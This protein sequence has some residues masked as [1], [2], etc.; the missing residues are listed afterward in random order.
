MT[1]DLSIWT[2]EVLGLFNDR[3][4]D[5]DIA[6][7][8][9]RSLLKELSQDDAKRWKYNP[10]KLIKNI[11]LATTA[12]EMLS[13]KNSKTIETHA[14]KTA[15][16]KLART[17]ESLAKLEERTDMLTATI[18]AAVLYEIAGYQANAAC[19]GKQI[20]REIIDRN[21]G[22]SDLASH[23]LR[24][25]FLQTGIIA[26]P[27]LREPSIDKE[28]DLLIED[29]A[30]ALAAKGFM[31]AGHYFLTGYK[32][33]MDKSMNSFQTSESVYSSLPKYY[34][35][36]LVNSI[37]CLLP[38]MQM[39]ST[40]SYFEREV[41]M[42]PKWERYL[43]LLARGP[44]SDI[45]R[46]PSVSELWPSQLYALNNGLFHESSKIIRMQT[47]AGK[48]RIA[49]LAMANTLITIPESKCVY[50]APYRALVGEL[51]ETFINVFGDLGYKV[52][53]IVDNAYALDDLEKELIN[54]ADI[55]VLTPEKL[56]LL[57][58]A[59]P[60]LLESVALFILDE[61]HIVDERARGIKFELL[62]SRLKRRLPNARFIFL[63][64]VVPQQTLDDFAE[65]FNAE[66]SDII[67]TDWRPSILRVASFEWKG[68]T[69]QIDYSPDEDMPIRE[70][71]PGVIKQNQYEMV[72]NK[73]KRTRVVFPDPTN[74]SETAAELAWKFAELGSVLVFCSQT[75]FV[76][77]VGKAL[78]T[79]LEYSMKQAESIPLRFDPKTSLSVSAAR[80][81]L[82]DNHPVTQL[83][84]RGIGI[85][86][87]TLPEV[88]RKSV[89]TD[90]RNRR[91]R[92]LV[93]TNTLAQGVNLP[94]RTVIVH[95][96]WRHV[97][98]QQKLIPAR[99]YWNIV[100]RAGR[101]GEETQG[102]AIHIIKSERDKSDFNFFLERRNDVEAVWSA[103]LKVLLEWLEKRIDQRELYRLI[104][105]EILA[106]L[107][108]EGEKF[109]SEE[110]IDNILN[111]TLVNVQAK[112]IPDLDMKPLRK[113]FQFAA[114][115]IAATVDTT[116]RPVYSS[117]GL[118]TTSCEKI[119][120]FVVDNDSMLRE[121]LTTAISYQ[122]HVPKLV[123]F[124]LTLEEME[125]DK[126]VNI[127]PS[128]MLLQWLQGR[129]IKD[130]IGYY[131]NDLEPSEITEFIENFFVYR[132]PWGI[133]GIIQIATKV[134]SL[135]KNNLSDLAKFFPSMIKYGV[136]SPSASWAVSAGI[137]FRDV[138][139]RMG[140]AYASK[141]SKHSYDDF[142]QYIGNLHSE[143]LHYEYNITS[144]FLEEVT[145]ALSK[146]STNPYL[147]NYKKDLLTIET[148]VAGI[149]FGRVPIATIAK[150][151]NQVEL[152]RE[153]DNEVDRNAI[154]VLLNGQQLGYLER[155]LAQRLA[156]DMD[157]G[158]QISGKIKEIEKGNIPQIRL[159]INA[160]ATS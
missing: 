21:P 112:R 31:D 86:Y 48:T 130:I 14:I 137:P 120:K 17:W 148:W 153:Y 98:D 150:V 136:P 117:T 45:L 81:W 78:M 44:G 94:I 119:R 156:P 65:W 12:L 60:E 72:N 76:K 115:S 4:F 151:G 67:S 59:K 144:P 97:D 79:R 126:E 55:L 82:G 62:L 11:T 91:F 105:K 50:I 64:A 70:F 23:F 90:F 142:L 110:N 85:H 143:E 19:L 42:Y 61:G 157:V 89:E 43:R 40:W 146:S 92:V 125:N 27:L 77:S 131:S 138:G 33:F 28:T 66:K 16:L 41:N 25:R 154:I 58:R 46:S 129:S 73:G 122:D 83:L 106:I 51:E 3:S 56:D 71:V 88:V 103:L 139:I 52:S 109:F 118:S 22:I 124:C 35:A 15:A 95:S 132:L 26:R 100:G 74:K 140:Q 47:S 113:A 127:N 10:A 159:S 9:S 53:T 34:D 84:S 152:V 7:I 101:A 80:E 49:E 30:L 32:T 121:F 5:Y 102:L 24:R 18:N 8:G 160:E 158:I 108:E 93:A 104:D 20:Y 111:E 13:K 75:N 99:D 128:E 87:G 29:M 149:R 38:L 114:S 107:T 133:S 54:Q 2:D 63:S 145:K 39:R 6:Q 36:N 134:L 147:R 57:H 69:G 1:E 135:E 155:S 141:T 68:S 96:C 123:E 37:S 116:L